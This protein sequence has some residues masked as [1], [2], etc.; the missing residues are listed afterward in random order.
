MATLDS[1]LWAACDSGGLLRG[2]LDGDSIVWESIFAQSP[3]RSVFA[4]KREDSTI[5]WIG[6]ADSGIYKFVYTFTETP[7]TVI[8]YTS[9]DGLSGDSVASVR[10]QSYVGT[11]VIWAAT[12]PTS[13][14]GEYGVSKSADFGVTWDTCLSGERVSDFAFE[15]SVVFAATSSGLKRSYDYG[16]SWE[17]LEAVDHDNNFKPLSPEFRSL[18]VDRHI[19]WAGSADGVC[20]SLDSGDSWKVF[21]FFITYRLALWAGTAAGIYKFIYTDSDSAD[22]VISYS[23]AGGSGISGDFV[24]ALEVQ[25]YD[26]KKIVWAGT[27]PAYEGYFGASRTTD[28]GESWEVFL[29]GDKIWNF[30]FDDSVAW[31]ATS[32]GLKRSTDLGESWEVF[33]YISDEQ[34]PDQRILSKEYYAVKV[35]GD[36]IWAGNFDGLVRIKK[37]AEVTDY[38]AVFRAYASAPPAYAYPSPFSPYL[39][40]GITRIH[41]EVQNPGEVTVKIYDFAMNLVTTINQKADQ[42]RE[43]DVVWDGRN[44]K[45]DLVANGVYFFKIESPGENQWGKV[46]VI[47]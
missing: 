33:K 18:F 47:K 9:E 15:D 14:G 37:D 5:V 2:I 35:A 32:S 31:A 6:T 45:G 40:T 24:V 29:N 16:E 42:K 43:Y 36:S 3:V 27:Q 28:G 41:F 17:D 10:Y 44:D 8:N 39:L 20:R 46:V 21:K 34:R 22:T 7:D 12:A 30:D 25:E 4:D 11:N 19:L 26:D 13:F 23:Y 38:G 1:A